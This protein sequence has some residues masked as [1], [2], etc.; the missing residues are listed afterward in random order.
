M[1]IIKTKERQF[2]ITLVDGVKTTQVKHVSEGWYALAHRLT[3]KPTVT[4][5]RESLK[6]LKSLKFPLF[7]PFKMV[8][9]ED[10]A[11]M[12]PDY[13]HGKQYSR[14]I[15]NTISADMIV[16]DIDNDPAKLERTNAD[17]FTIDD[18][19]VFFNDLSY[20]I[21]T[22]YNHRNPQKHNVDKFRVI[23][24]LTEPVERSDILERKEELI[25]LFPMVD[26]MSFTLSQPFYVP[27][28]HPTREKLHKAFF[29]DGAEF[30]LFALQPV[31]KEE[32]T[33]VT[34]VPLGKIKNLE[35][36]PHIKLKSGI[37][38]RA[39]ELYDVLAEGYAGRKQ[40]FR[41]G[42]SD[43]T[44]GCFIYRKGDGLMYKDNT[45]PKAQFF[46]V[47]DVRKEFE[48]PFE[49]EE[50]V[51]TLPMWSR[52]P[53]QSAVAKTPKRS[54]VSAP[55]VEFDH[56][57]LEALE[58]N[59]R[60]LPQ[61]LIHSIPVEG[62][63]LIRSPKGTGKTE[64]LKSVT[65]QADANGHR[66]MLLGHRQ[67]LLQNLA[68]RTD[69]TNYQDLDDGKT[70][71]AMTLC[72]N[73]LTRLDPK[74]DEP[75]HT[76]IID[77]SEQVLCYLTSQLLHRNLKEIFDA[78][79][80]LFKTAKRIILLDADLSPDL[81]IQL[82]EYLRG[83]NGKDEHVLSIVNK[84]QIG[85]DKTTKMY[86]KKM[87]LLADALES[88]VK[89]EKVFIAT[90][91]IKFS[92]V[93]DAIVKE[94][95]KSSLLITQETNDS[96]AALAF[97]DDPKIE[98]TK[99][100]VVV[101]SPTLST[102][103]SIEGNHFTKVYGFF[104]INPGTFQDIDQ[105]ISR[106]R[107]CDDVS[108]WVQGHVSAV[109]LKS[110]ENIFNDILDKERKSVKRL[111]DAQEYANPGQYLWASIYACVTFKLSEW[112][113]NK[114]EKF[115]KLRTNLGFT[116]EHVLE[117]EESVSLGASIFNDFKDIGTNR[118]EL[119]F[120][121]EEID[122]DVAAALG[123]KTQRTREE[124]LSL[125]RY[126]LYQELKSDWSLENVNKAI[127]QEL[128]KS[129]SR[130]DLLH[131]V[132]DEVREN[133]DRADREKNQGLITANRHR[134]IRAEL[135]QNLC[136]AANINL[137]ALYLKLEKDKS[138]IEIDADT[139]L[140]VADAY[141]AKKKDFNFYFNSRIKDPKHEKNLKKVWDTI[142]GEELSLPLIKKKLGTRQKRV[143]HYYI[144]AP[145]NDL[146][147]ASFKQRFDV[148]NQI[149]KAFDKQ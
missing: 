123:R 45:S 78:L 44:A 77:E 61:E 145:E 6:S 72:I 16:L 97:I 118:G 99:Y 75:Y 147:Y 59:E 94:L 119:V 148:G 82:V 14:C 149:L 117:D 13:G 128:L 86:E 126:R 102:G 1:T 134:V 120:N 56:T 42:G 107:N 85:A 32:S 12:Q 25:K 116:I 17:P 8:T 121:A 62:V 29:N 34:Y 139:L 3:R 136:T 9:V 135:I 129:L 101:S 138:L 18:A 130:I 103:V 96:P 127:K 131:M 89:G 105:A 48:N 11:V 66:V 65:A 33:P 92:T 19:R 137:T 41:I 23:L 114:D 22:T 90:N 38:Y 57:S 43:K 60:Y 108:V 80:W 83:I 98:C 106:V 84:F 26:E 79:Q 132:T 144:S 74:K 54:A 95:G 58:L 39:D 124:Q 73:S 49:H 110:E 52:K 27:I 51:E 91:S 55:L 113:L 7:V 64:L 140:A 81:T 93:I 37:T 111:Y 68:M 142:F 47:M 71:D 112:S 100:D 40:C 53:A 146:V 104:G 76:L 2:H 30:D 15:A 24:P 109:E 70:N 88:I 4:E 31:V 21:Y 87:H 143:V 115:E 141:E 69:L 35:D 36:L 5:D 133:A 28:V 67:F 50:E 46:K 20:I 122:A 10:G 63:T 125:E